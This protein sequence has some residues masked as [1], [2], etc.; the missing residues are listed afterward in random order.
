MAGASPSARHAH[1]FDNSGSVLRASTEGKL[2]FLLF[3]ARPIKVTPQVVARGM[4]DMSA[5]ERESATPLRAA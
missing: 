3:A 5:K 2:N 4:K 1:V